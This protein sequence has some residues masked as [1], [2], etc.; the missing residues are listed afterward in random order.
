MP[1]VGHQ[2]YEET[3]A[4]FP[5]LLL[6]GHTLDRRMWQ[7]VAPRLGARY[8]VIMPDLAGHGLSR[9]SGVP[10]AD[11]L[12]ALLDGL[13]VARAAVCG[14]SMGGGAAVSL[15]IQHP[16]RVAALI[17]VDAALNGYRFA[18]WTGPKP[19]IA[20][21][22]SQ[23]LEAGLTAWLSDP[24]FAPAASRPDV[25]AQA[26]V[27]VRDYPGA[28]WL[29]GAWSPTPPGPPEPE[30]LGEV[31]APTLVLVGEHDLSDFHQIADL[32]AQRIA[33][34]RR[35]TVAGSG[36]MVPMEQPDAFTDAVEQFLDE[37]LR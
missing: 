34:A 24:I 35:L 8:R 11:D 17:A 4:G 28:A 1:Y 27:I 18:T 15:A 21:A 22:R 20:I 30:R 32:L 10:Q 6:H 36:H 9:P 26:A 23:G 16:G 14:L 37:V 3:G 19:Y 31:K 2:Y 25:A 12:A 13:G 7:A 29:Q 33:G 5:L